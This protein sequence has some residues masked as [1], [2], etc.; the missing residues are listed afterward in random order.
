MKHE[1]AAAE[2]N[3]DPNNG[4]YEESFD[5]TDFDSG[6]ARFILFRLK[7]GE[8]EP[9]SRSD[10]S[11]ERSLA[12]WRSNLLKSKK[13]NTLNADRKAVLASIGFSFSTRLDCPSPQLLRYLLACK[14]FALFR[15]AKRATSPFGRTDSLWKS[16]PVLSSHTFW[17]TGARTPLQ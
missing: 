7:N 2:D 8:K 9:D 11:G 3:D 12:M 15:E 10:S 14:F 6:V 4:S 17:R 5:P 13:S 16:P 1:Q